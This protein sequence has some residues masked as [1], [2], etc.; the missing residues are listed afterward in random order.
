MMEL[1]IKGIFS[2]LLAWDSNNNICI[3]GNLAVGNL[4]S[5]FHTRICV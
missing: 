5:N 1:W 2:V 4:L 3:K